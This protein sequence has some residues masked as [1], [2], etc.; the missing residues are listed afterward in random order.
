MKLGIYAEYWH[1]NRHHQQLLLKC[2]IQELDLL[3][4]YSGE[5]AWADSVSTIPFDVTEITSLK[6]I[7]RREQEELPQRV[8]GVAYNG[9][10]PDMTY[11]ADCEGTPSQVNGNDPGLTYERDR[12]V[13]MGE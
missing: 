2:E 12:T 4:R 9:D 1:N 11:Q 3:M 8:P 6:F 13:G 5:S 10:D 7:I